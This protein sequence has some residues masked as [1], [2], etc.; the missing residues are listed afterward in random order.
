MKC[1]NRTIY[2]QLQ[3]GVRVIDL[4]IS[5]LFDYRYSNEMEYWCSHSF[6]TVPLRIV[7]SDIRKFI[8]ENPTEVVIVEIK[9]D[10]SPINA[11]NFFMAKE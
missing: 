3:E 1:Q 7:L 10:W 4:R 2:Q 8:R 11:D 9:G 5:G 6:L